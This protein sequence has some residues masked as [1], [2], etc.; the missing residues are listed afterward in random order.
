M[1]K[2]QAKQEIREVKKSEDKEKIPL[3][4]ETEGPNCWDSKGPNCQDSEVPI[5]NCLGVVSL[6]MQLVASIE[7]F[8]MRAMSIALLKEL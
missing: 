7:F 2:I 5:E 4:L 6:E 3:K 8:I 1:S